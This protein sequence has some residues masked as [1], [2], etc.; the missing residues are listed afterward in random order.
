MPS[1]AP[2]KMYG[3]NRQGLDPQEEGPRDED[4]TGVLPFGQRRPT[5]R[6]AQGGSVVDGYDYA[7]GGSVKEKKMKKGGKV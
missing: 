4:R 1:L 2:K 7:H 3:M 6:M 5:G